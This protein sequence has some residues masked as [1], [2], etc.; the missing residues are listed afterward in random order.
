MV[1]FISDVCSPSSIALLSILQLCK[2]G[3]ALHSATFVHFSV[4][5]VLCLSSCC[6]LGCY[7][8]SVRM[9]KAFPFVHHELSDGRLC[10]YIS[11]T[12]FFKEVLPPFY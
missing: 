3:A 2:S 5:A 6:L 10:L 4:N 8:C 11:I 1:S 12:L 7:F 9:K